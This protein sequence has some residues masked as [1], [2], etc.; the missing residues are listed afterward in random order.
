MPDEKKKIGEVQHL[1]GFTFPAKIHVCKEFEKGGAAVVIATKEDFFEALSLIASNKPIPPEMLKRI[2]IIT[3]IE[4]ALESKESSLLIPD[5]PDVS[6]MFLH[7]W[8]EK[9]THGLTCS[10]C[11][12]Y[13]ENRFCIEYYNKPC[14]P[15]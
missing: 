9:G 2:G 11:G 7:D 8:Q 6:N 13:V 3:N 10:K 12:G 4:P 14:K 5:D 1:A 15:T